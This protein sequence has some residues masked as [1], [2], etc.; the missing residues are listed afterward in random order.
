RVFALPQ[1]NEATQ[2]MVQDR[3]REEN[4]HARNVIIILVVIACIFAAFTALGLILFSS[5]I[6][7]KDTSIDYISTKLRINKDS[8]LFEEVLAK[9]KVNFEKDAY[10]KVYPEKVTYTLSTKYIKSRPLNV[11][12]TSTFQISKTKQA[13]EVKFEPHQFQLSKNELR[14]L[15]NGI[16]NREVFLQFSANYRMK[17]KGTTSKAVVQPDLPERSSDSERRSCGKSCELA[18]GEPPE[19]H[20]CPHE[21]SGTEPIL[22]QKPIFFNPF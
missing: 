8:V 5:D 1:T 3:E 10:V 4:G 22:A 16:E 2:R 20:S 15:K 6:Q 7:L 13:I 14:H 11:V 21:F 19:L 17:M 12:Y 18:V 9:P